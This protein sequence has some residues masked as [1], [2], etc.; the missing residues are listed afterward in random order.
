MSANTFDEHDSQALR[1][2]IVVVASV[3]I[4]LAFAHRIVTRP[5]S[6]GYLGFRLRGEGATLRPPCASWPPRRRPRPLRAIVLAMRHRGVLLLVAT[7]VFGCSPEGGSAVGTDGLAVVDSSPIWNMLGTQ[8]GARLGSVGRAGDVD[9]DGYDDILVS[10]PLHDELFTDDGKVWLYLGSTTGPEASPNWSITGG[11]DG[12]RCRA[13]GVGDVDG[14]GFDDVLAGI[15]QWDGADVD[16]GKVE[17][18]CGNA[19]GLGPLPCWS[20][21]GEQASGQVTVGSARG[22]GDVN[23][24]GYA[25]LVVPC[26]GCEETIAGEGTMMLFLGGPAGPASEPDLVWGSGQAGAGANAAIVGDVNGDGFDDVAFANYAYDEVG[27]DVGRVQLFLG[28]ASGVAEVATWSAFGSQVGEKLGTLLAPAGDVD[29]DGYADVAAT[30]PRYDSSSIVNAGRAVVWSGSPAGLSTLPAWTWASPEPPSVLTGLSRVASAGDIDGDGRA[31]LLS[32]SYLATPSQEGRVWLHLGAQ[33]GLH[34]APDWTSGPLIGPDSQSFFGASL[35]SAGDTDGDGRTELLVAADNWN[36]GRGSAHVVAGDPAWPASSPQQVIHGSQEN[37]YLGS[38]TRSVVADFDADGREDLLGGSTWWTGQAGDGAGGLWVWPGGTGG[39]AGSATWFLEG[40]QAGGRLGGIPG[41]GDFNGDGHLDLASGEDA[42][43]NGEPAEGRAL[44]V[45]GTATGLGGSIDWSWE[46]DVAEARVGIA[47]A[48][49]DF[50]G[51]GFDDLVVAA[52]AWA[53]SPGAGSGLWLFEGG[54]SGLSDLPSWAWGSDE[55]GD[56]LSRLTVGDLDGDGSPDL[57]AGA[58]HSDSWA[59]DGGLV[60]VF[61]NG[62]A[63]LPSTPSWSWSSGFPGDQ[64]PT[65]LRAFDVDGDGDDELA[66]SSSWYDANAGAVWILEGTVLGPAAVSPALLT[67]DA[68]RFGGGLDGG[69]LDGDGYSEL[70]VTA[71][72]LGQVLVYAGSPTGLDLSAP[73]WTLTTDP[74]EADHPVRPRLGDLDG[75]GIA[76]LALGSSATAVVWA[77]EGSLTTHLGGTG[78]AGHPHVHPARVRVRHPGTDDPIAPGGVSASSTSFDLLYDA[79][80]SRGRAR[81]TLQVEVKAQ[82]IPFDGT[83]LRESADWEDILPGGSDL[84]L[85]VDGLEPGTSYHWRARLHFDKAQHP[86]IRQTRWIYGDVAHP[87]GVHLR[88]NP[89]TDS[90]GDPDSSDCAPTDPTIHSAAPELC[91]GIDDSCAGSVASAEIDDDGDG[92]RECE[93]DCDDGDPAVH[94]DAPEGCDGLDTDCD[95][96][97]DPAELDDDGDQL[98]ECEGDCDDSDAAIKPS[99]QEACNGIDDD[100]DT[101]IDADDEELDLDQDGVAACEGDCDDGD[102]NI[103]PAEPEGCDGIDTDCD[104]SLGASETD[105]DGDFVS[106]CE[107]DCDDSTA[108]VQPAAAEGCTGVDDDCDGLVDLADPD[109]DLDDDGFAWCTGD[110][111]D[112]DPVINPG[113]LEGCD[114]IDTD[115][116]GAL[117]GDETDDDGDNLTECVGDCDDGDPA[118][119]PSADEVCDGLDN[120]CDALVDAADPDTDRDGDGQSACDDDCDDNDPN[121]WSGAP[122]ACDAIDQDCDGD[123]VEGYDDTDGDGILDCLDDDADGD[124]SSGTPDCDDTDPSIHPDADEG[125]NGVD[126]DCSGAPWPGEVDQD[127][128]GYVACAPYTGPLGVIQG[129]GDCDDDTAQRSPGRAEECDAAALDNDCDGLEDAADPDLVWLPYY[130]DSDGD[131]FGDVDAPFPAGLA[132]SPPAGHV[133][134]ATDCDDAAPGVHPGANEV[135]GNGADDDCV[136]GDEPDPGSVARAAPGISCGG[137]VGGG[138]GG[139]LLLLPLF[140]RRGRGMAAARGGRRRAVG[141]AGSELTKRGAA[142]LC[143]Q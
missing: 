42:W 101:L 91:N 65:D 59:S 64:L 35:S 114:G 51:D 84:R 18:Y 37:Q 24:D 12:V 46:L 19:A 54:P 134:D 92:T 76:D 36:S 34:L 129:D 88:T 69:D 23:A 135:P 9:N 108:A 13:Y 136:G 6:V 11:Q 67:Q 100:C 141:S 128:D 137:S 8:T 85:T 17:L 63:G 40:A 16:V 48:A 31:D 116:D 7:L 140:C 57:A 99:A 21:E 22:G 126:D 55:P 106:E 80:S 90:D 45:Y 72:D 143:W 120:D 109:L 127:G 1:L 25:D 111:D 115:C 81:C 10:A 94:P 142:S 47:V 83:D 41:A 77:N 87:A 118:I 53:D 95:G 33:G 96:S 29:A 82:G 74:S 2:L 124:G 86:P 71:S 104:G 52:H 98:A 30:G 49:A 60:L 125:C 50:D 89:D 119:N 122:E 66:F 73:A 70:V 58:I 61:M 14:D 110:C 78:P 131:G 107:G 139:L 97:I 56:E 27:A 130:L 123:T 4:A 93:G 121:A 39:L 32:A 28:E 75:D 105:D 132:C 3:L 68:G 38:G 103:G 113:A 133:L 62:G 43:S 5:G 117:G 15:P 138:S 44:A 112:S 26:Y 20:H 102:P 79:W